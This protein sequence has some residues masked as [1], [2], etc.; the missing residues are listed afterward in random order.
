MDPED[1]HFRVR[2]TCTPGLCPQ[3]RRN[4]RRRIGKNCIPF[5]ERQSQEGA[6]FGLVFCMTQGTVNSGSAEVVGLSQASPSRGFTVS[7]MWIDGGLCLRSLL[8]IRINTNVC[9]FKTKKEILEGKKKS[10]KAE[11]ERSPGVV[12]LCHVSSCEWKSFSNR[13]TLVK[14]TSFAVWEGKK[15]KAFSLLGDF[16]CNPASVILLL[17]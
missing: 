2:G 14:V 6:L 12:F 10:S 11:K 4:F 3:K 9:V 8:S 5:L 17:N 1:I 13:Q 16:F 15:L 7:L